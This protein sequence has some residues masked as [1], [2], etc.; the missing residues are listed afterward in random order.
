M[1]RKFWSRNLKWKPR[2]RMD[3]NIKMNVKEMGLEW[4][5]LTQNKDKLWGILL[6]R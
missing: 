1:R 5:H 4:I 6:T 3:V 2:R